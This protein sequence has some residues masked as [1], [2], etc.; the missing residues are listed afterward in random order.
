MIP[1]TMPQ[2]RPG[3]RGS[4]PALLLAASTLCLGLAAC[5]SQ[6]VVVGAVPEDYRTNHPITI[7]ENLATMDIP[8]GAETASL[9]R[10]MDENILAFAD[11]FID[12][13]AAELAIVLPSGSGNASVAAAIAGQVEQILL[14]GGV[15][16]SAIGYRSYAA[17]PQETAAPIRLAFVQ[18][19]A[20]TEP[21]GPWTDDV[22]DTN[23]NRYYESFGCATQQN[24]AAIVS[25]P[26]DLLYPRQSAPPSAAR[27]SGVLAN[28]QAGQP[29]ETV[30]GDFGTS[31]TE[32]GQ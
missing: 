8:V 15:P 31:T 26:L 25:N 21:C 22:S 9:A 2:K 23:D 19:A 11:A 27:R 18:I 12:A 24:F 3:S 1:R 13:G 10:G 4:R 14:G 6:R 7:S 17:H 30:Y 16:L 5:S 28:Y 20:S 32:Q 29:T